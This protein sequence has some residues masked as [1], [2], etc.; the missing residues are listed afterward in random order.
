MKK[1][2][3]IATIYNGHSHI[4]RV[5][6]QDDKGFRYVKINGMLFDVDF[7]LKHYEVKIWYRG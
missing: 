1:T 7:E 4:E 3:Y 5:V 6:Y 2:E